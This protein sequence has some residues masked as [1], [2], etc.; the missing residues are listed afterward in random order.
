MGS[1]LTG[2]IVVKDG[3]GGGDQFMTGVAVVR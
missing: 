1:V 2:N 3:S